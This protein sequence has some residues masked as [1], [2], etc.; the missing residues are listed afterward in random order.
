MQ[1]LIKIFFPFIT[2]FVS[3]SFAQQTEIIKIE[4]TRKQL[5]FSL[6]ENI[7]SEKPIVA[8]ALSG[9][10]ARG[11]AQIGVLKALADAD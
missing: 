3:I 11:F 2:F 1:I 10:G 4:T 9:G 6:S 8:L 7:S 5:P